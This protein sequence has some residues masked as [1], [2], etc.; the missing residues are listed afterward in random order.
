MAAARSNRGSEL[1]KKWG[2]G[3]RHSLYRKTGDWYHLPKRFPAALFDAHGYIRFETEAD[4]KTDGI[5]T[6]TRE[7][8]NWLSVKK[9]GISALSDYVRIISGIGDVWTVDNADR[10]GFVDL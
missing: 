5:S 7:G 10:T 6:S 3:A 9:P 4:L 2:V 8:K 1:N